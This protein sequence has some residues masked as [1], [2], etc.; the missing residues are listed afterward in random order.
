MR[1]LYGYFSKKQI[2]STKEYLRKRIFFLL[3]CVDPNTS[4][5]LE[6]VDVNACFKGLLYKIGGLN[7]LL[8]RPP[9]LVTALSLLQSAQ[10][11]YNSQHFEFENYKMLILEAGAEIGK[12]KEV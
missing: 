1:H 10:M 5:G 7:K 11:E 8:R 4:E 12:I 3:V 2:K 6:Y 9:E